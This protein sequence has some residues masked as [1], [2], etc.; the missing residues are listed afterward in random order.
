M[1]VAPVKTMAAES[2]RLPAPALPTSGCEYQVYSRSSGHDILTTTNVPYSKVFVEA[3][4]P[5]VGQSTKNGS[6]DDL[7]TKKTRC[8]VGPGVVSY[9]SELESESLDSSGGK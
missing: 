3:R 8:S 7:K 2:N 5:H 4:W 9:L 6:K 1:Y